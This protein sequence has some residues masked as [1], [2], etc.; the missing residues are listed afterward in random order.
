LALRS[1]NDMVIVRGC[2]CDLSTIKKLGSSGLELR[3]NPKV[4]SPPAKRSGRHLTTLPI[5]PAVASHHQPTFAHRTEFTSNPE[6]IVHSQYERPREHRF[7][8][9]MADFA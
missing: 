3:Q 1:W 7:D 2:C 4:R 8:G 5:Q 9:G 6:Y